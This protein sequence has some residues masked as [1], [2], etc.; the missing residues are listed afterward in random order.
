MGITLPEGINFDDL[1]SLDLKKAMQNDKL[2][3]IIKDQIKE[4]KIDIPSGKNIE[5]VLSSN[6]EMKN[7]V[8]KGMFKDIG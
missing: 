7:N 8:L 2:Q 5:D 4:L 6:K 3:N 1:S